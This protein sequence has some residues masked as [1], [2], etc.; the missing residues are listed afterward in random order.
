MLVSFSLPG[1]PLEPPGLPWVPR[2]RPRSIFWWFLAVPGEALEPLLGPVGSLWAP[3]G[4]L[5]AHL[6]AR[7]GDKSVKRST[8]EAHWVP[9]SILGAKR[10]GPG[11][12]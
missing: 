9:E 1:V 8:P 2:W 6:G 11:P 4:H 3:L 12:S 5:W 10:E 7:R